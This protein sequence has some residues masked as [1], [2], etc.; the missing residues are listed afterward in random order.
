[1]GKLLDERGTV[2][3]T[4]LKRIQNELL[5]FVDLFAI[6][7]FLKCM[8]HFRFSFPLLYLGLFASKV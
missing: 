2:K 6:H 4:T 7:A 5:V 8:Q 1:M 3:N